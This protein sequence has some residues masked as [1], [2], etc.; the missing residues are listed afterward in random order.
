MSIEIPKTYDFSA[1]ETRWYAAWE[2]RGYFH[3]DPASPKPPFVIVI[4]PP[5]VTGSLHM[6]HMLDQTIQD[7]VIRRKRMQ[8]FNALWLPGTDHAGIAT[9]NVVEKQLRE[10]GLTRHD[11]GR[12]R[13]V[14]RVWAWKRESGDVIARQLRRLGASCD[15]SRERFTLDEGLSRAVR[16][17]FVRLYE[18]GLIYRGE[19]LIHWCPRC[20]TALSDLEVAHTEIAGR[21]Y[22]IRY[23]VEGAAGDFIEVATTR[24]ETMLGDTGLAV[25]P[26]D[27]RY[28]GLLGARGRLPLVGRE[29]PFVADAIVDR[30]FGTGIVKVTPAHDPNDFEI[31]ERHGLERVRVIDEDARITGEGGVYAGLDRFEA[32]KRVVEDLDA[33]GYLTAVEDHRHNVGHCSRCRT[34]SEPLLSTQ[35]FVRTAPLAR[36][37]VEAVRTG[38]TRFVP[39]NWSK[40]YFEWM[41]KIRDWCVSRQLWWGHRIPAWHCD[42]CGGITVSRTDPDA[43][44]H[45][46]SGALSQD[47]DVLDTWFSSQL[48]P[49]STMG[50]P[51]ETPELRV[52]YPTHLLVTGYDIIFFWVARMVMAGKHFTGQAPFREVYIHGLLRDAER[53]KLSK[54]K[55]N[56]GDP[57]LACDHYGTDAVRFTMASLGAPGSD[58]ILV[59][60]QL[61][62]HRAFATKIWNAARYILG[63]VDAS[64]RLPDGDAIRAMDLSL[65]DRWILSRHMRAVASVNDAL[66]GYFLHEASKSIRQFFWRDFCDWYLEMTKLHPAESRPV[67]LYVL[68]SS[69]RLLHPFMPFLTE[70]LWQRMPHRGESIVVADYPVPRDDL[71]DAASERS[72]ELIQEIIVKVRNV[73]AEM[74]VDAKTRLPL[75]IAG[76]DRATAAMLSANAAYVRRLARVDA[77]DFVAAPSEAR[78]AA[79]AVAGP[80][81]LEIPLAGVLDLEA[82][83]ARLRREIDKVR[84]EIAGLERKLGNAKF[85]D[86]AP[87]EVVEENRQRLAGYRDQESRLAEGLDR[88]A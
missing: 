65:A 75:R 67:L 33:Q 81:S 26:D 12:D 48:W 82:E 80:V 74:N 76:A 63:H 15:W 20:R 59:E 6:G 36:E 34:V 78:A 39:E 41:R 30:E 19:R 40:T 58:I 3:A 42:G 45:C 21:L 52:F 47:E 61:E 55:G 86:R 44:A 69:L 87:R 66:E 23:P 11:L 4:P 10:E 84:K 70:E 60:S 28:A 50:W 72:A 64:A 32:R 18:E 57:M 54:S 77:I 79:R 73:R 62:S 49:F 88:L 46:R 31:G 22:R 43:C 24:P 83:Q 7:V 53:R 27:A 51:D 17:V 9:Q 38:E 8:G 16:E 13:F 37:A 2:S 5:N 35:W 71:I 25:H 29:L 56:A 68:E 85:V 14:E 1:V